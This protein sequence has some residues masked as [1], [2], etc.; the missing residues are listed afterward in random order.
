[1]IHTS[2]LAKRR[3]HEA[4]VERAGRRRPS[5]WVPRW[6]AGRRSVRAVGLANPSLQDARASG[7]DSQPRPDNRICWLS[8]SRQVRGALG[9]LIAKGAPRGLAHPWRLPALHS[10]FGGEGKRDR[11]C[12]HLDERAA[13]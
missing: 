10:L 9:A 2:W 8:Q 4:S 1:M 12:P 3:H 6:S 13:L 7:W 5:Y 11:V